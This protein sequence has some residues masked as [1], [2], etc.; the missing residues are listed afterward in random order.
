MFVQAKTFSLNQKRR[1]LKKATRLLPISVPY[2]KKIEATP[3]K[4]RTKRM[5]FSPRL[6]FSARFKLTYLCGLSRSDCCVTVGCATALPFLPTCL[7][8]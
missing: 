4:Q 6:N 1:G 2:K 5:M 8:L 3:V 7:L